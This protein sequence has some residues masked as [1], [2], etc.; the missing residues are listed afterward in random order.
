M[1]L[2]SLKFYFEI[3]AGRNSL[4]RKRLAWQ[5]FCVYW[6]VHDFFPLSYKL[7]RQCRARKKLLTLWR[8]DLMDKL[9]NT[10]VLFKCVLCKFFCLFKNKLKQIWIFFKAVR[11]IY[12][13]CSQTSPLPT[14]G[15]L[16][17]LDIAPDEVINHAAYFCVEKSIVSWILTEHQN[18]DVCSIKSSFFKI[19]LSRI[20]F[21]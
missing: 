15:P 2:A 4:S 11:F 7:R 16:G 3:Q 8:I 6:L 10:Y 12:Q 20:H 13:F 18:A 14:F 1:F 9:V 17:L 21:G 5:M 19:N